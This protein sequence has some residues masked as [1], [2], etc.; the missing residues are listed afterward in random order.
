[1]HPQI[2]LNYAAVI[3]AAILSF[4]FSFLW[5]GPLFGKTWARLQGMDMTKKP[6]SSFMTRAM[7]LQL[8]GL[9][10]TAYVLA[11][12]DNVWRP[13]NWAF[14]NQDKPGYVYGFLGGFFTW[15]GFYIP[16]LLGSSTWE[17]KPWKLFYLN[18]A[19]NFLNLQI[20]SMVVACW[21]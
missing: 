17:G 12:T 21:R 18:A 11:Y 19:Y 15:L 8:L 5:Y 3:L 2:H 7:A 14:G 4:V 1:M 20:I 6:D 13:S 9:I 10:F 16:T